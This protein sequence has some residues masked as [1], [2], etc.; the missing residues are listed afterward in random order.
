[1]SVP[2]PMPCLSDE[3]CPA[4]IACQFAGSCRHRRIDSA[5]S[6]DEALAECKRRGIN[7]FEEK[8]T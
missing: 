3:P 8:R 1:M 2:D 6:Y 7:P 5:R 4:P